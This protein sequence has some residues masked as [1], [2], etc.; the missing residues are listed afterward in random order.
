MVSYLT[1]LK[2]YGENKF[3]DTNYYGG[4]VPRVNSYVED[5]DMIISNYYTDGSRE[6]S[7]VQVFTPCST[8]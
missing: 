6:F 1:M 5:L 3:T 4:F 7:L 2:T 8:I